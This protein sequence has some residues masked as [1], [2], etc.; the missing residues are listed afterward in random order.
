MN[1]PRAAAIPWLLAAQK[2]RFSA[3][4]ITRAPNSVRPYRPNRR[5][6]P[7]STTMVSNST[8]VCRATEARQARS[9][10]C[11][12]QLTITTEINRLCYQGSGRREDGPLPPP[13]RVCNRYGGR[14]LKR[15]PNNR[16]LN[17]TRGSVS[18]VESATAF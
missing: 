17:L 10:L 15:A 13:A 16:L 11:R 18:G 6:E 8:P 3:L 1:S 7:L 9:R 4:R 2:P 14:S 5:V 12:F